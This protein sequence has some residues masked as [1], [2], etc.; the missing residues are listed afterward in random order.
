M[1]RVSLLDNDHSDSSIS[2]VSNISG[3]VDILS[4]SANNIVDIGDIDILSTSA[5]TTMAVTARVTAREPALVS[6]VGSGNIDNLSAGVS[7]I[8]DNDYSDNSSAITS[9]SSHSVEWR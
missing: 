9:T 2:N 1:P 3:D 4:V 5:V 6:S 7:S 8:I